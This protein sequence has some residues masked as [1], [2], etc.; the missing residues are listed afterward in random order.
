M[1]AETIATAGASVTVYDHMASVGRKLFLAG[2]GGLNIT[3]SESLDQF[4]GRY[5]AARP[6][7]ERAIRAFGPTE[8]RAWCS[9]LGQE[10]FVGSGG[11]VFPSGFRATPLLRAWLHRLSALDVE[12]KLR[13]SWH[14]WEES[15]DAPVA[16]TFSDA[17]GRPI[18]V[19]AHAAVLAMG[20]ASWPRVGS[21]GAWVGPMTAGGVEVTPLRPSNCGFVVEWTAVFR[22]RFAG[23]PLKNV[24]LS[25]DGTSVRGEAMITTTGIEGGGV[26]ALSAALRDAIEAGR[27]AVLHVDLHPDRSIDDLAERVT[28]RSSKESISTRLQRAV[29]LPPVAIGLLRESTGNRL[30]HEPLALARLLKSAPLTLIAP[31]PIERAIST[32]GGVGFDQ[33]DDS[34]MLR[35]H[36]GTFVAG[37][38]LDWEAPTGGYLLQATFSTA[39]AAA[40]AAIER[41]A[42]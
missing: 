16:M 28:R 41:L 12:I 7:L 29:G 25:F 38:M 4:L 27:P 37:E 13:H 32:A 31:Q 36:P 21:D 18:T 34:F 23:T 5:G 24:M 14:G 9:G 1:A 11:R 39:V 8:L 33:V 17:D 19:V 42:G 20:G 2:R 10:P 15:D 6:R 22:D 26:Y 35:S 40:T 30:P 3:H